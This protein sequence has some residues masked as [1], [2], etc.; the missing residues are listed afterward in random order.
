MKNTE[1]HTTNSDDNLRKKAEDQL[2]NNPTP[3]NSS[4]YEG[5]TLK[6]IHEL[7]VHQ[8]ELVMQNEELREAHIA[9]LDAIELYDYAPTGYFTLSKDGTIVGLNLSGAETLH[10]DKSSLKE[11]KFGSFVNEESKEIFNN[12][13]QRIF[14]T[15]TKETCEITLFTIGYAPIHVILT[16]AIGKNEDQCFITSINITALKQYE[17]N[18]Q[19]EKGIIRR[20]SQ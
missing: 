8:I 14:N 7:Q 16:G 2:K 3:A 11:S 4:F 9:A 20:Y 5:D 6:L 13:L 1:Q 15:K 10:K 12:F 18:L 19:Y 17:A